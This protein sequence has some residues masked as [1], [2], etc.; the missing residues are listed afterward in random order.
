ML[1]GPR[2]KMR[3][4]EGVSADARLLFLKETAPARGATEAVFLGTCRGFGVATRWTNTSRDLFL[5]DRPQLE[6]FSHWE[7]MALEKPRAQ[8]HAVAHQQKGYE[9]PSASEQRQL[10]ENVAL[11]IRSWNP[12]R[13]EPCN[14]SHVTPIR[15]ALNGMSRPKV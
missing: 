14:C 2:P 15:F 8:V 1:H 13:Q 6:G 5:N 11:R 9:Q 7:T 12:A 10:Y 4:R 3:R